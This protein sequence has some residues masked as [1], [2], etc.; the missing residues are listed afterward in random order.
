MFHCFVVQFFA[1]CFSQF[2]QYS[3]SKAQKYSKTFASVHIIK[4]SHQNGST[5]YRLFFTPSQLSAKQLLQRLRK[6]S[7]SNSNSIV[8]KFVQHKKHLKTKA[9]RASRKRP[10]II[11]MSFLKTMLKKKKFYSKNLKHFEAIIIPFLRSA[12]KIKNIFFIKKTSEPQ[13]TV[14]A[15]F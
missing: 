6:E 9:S 5:K 8:E 12:F 7:Q 15:Q 11:I 4:V 3:C 10:K 1:H 13:G 2:T 14:V